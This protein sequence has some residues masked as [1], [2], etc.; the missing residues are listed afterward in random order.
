MLLIRMQRFAQRKMNTAIPLGS[1]YHD[2]GLR[3]VFDKLDLSFQVIRHKF[4]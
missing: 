3:K 4:C 1:L 2:Q